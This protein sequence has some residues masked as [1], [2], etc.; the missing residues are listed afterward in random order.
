MWSSKQ[1]HTHKT[2]KIIIVTTVTKLIVQSIKKEKGWYKEVR[3]DSNK[4]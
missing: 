2:N 1:T 3:S 4:E